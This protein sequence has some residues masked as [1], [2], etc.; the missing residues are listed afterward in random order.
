M[1]KSILPV[2]PII[3][4]PL[5]M[6]PGSASADSSGNNE[7]RWYCEH[8]NP[9]QSN[10]SRCLGGGSRGIAR[11]D[12]NND[13]FAD[14][15]V[16]IPGEDTPAGTFSSG[17]VIVIY[18]SAN[19][20]TGAGTG[21][22]TSQFWSQNSPG[23]PGDSEPADRFGSALAGGDFNAAPGDGAIV[24]GVGSRGRVVVI[25]GSS[26]G[27][28][29]AAGTGRPAAQSWALGDLNA[30]G[31]LLLF[32]AA[33]E[34]DIPA[35]P[36]F[37][38]GSA[39]AWGDFDGDG[40]GDLAVGAPEESLLVPIPVFPQS[41]QAGAVG[42]FFGTRANGLTA[43]RSKVGARTARACRAMPQQATVLDRRWQAAI[44]PRM[45]PRTW[46]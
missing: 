2:L 4:A 5:A 11:A 9:P 20:L 17:A 34:E 8:G 39:L 35:S 3:L 26:A 36:T 21:V 1:P 13:G 32:S 44:S 37:N 27:L 12:F 30:Q 10:R 7:N 38:F 23:I 45:V 31:Q 28:N 24:N 42:I 25:Y 19:G 29:A 46:Q 15:A 41:V 14:L 43:N 18:G 33:S 22:P 16:G 6:N 40:V